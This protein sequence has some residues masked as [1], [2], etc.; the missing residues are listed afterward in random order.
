MADLS[1]RRFLKA[2]GT[3][4]A[5]AGA[6]LL[7]GGLA[8][9]DTE[10]SHPGATTLPYPR[11]GIAKASALK[12]NEPKAFS[13]P[14]E[15]SFC[16]VIKLGR[17]V[18]GGVGPDGDIVA[19]STQC[20]HMGCPLSYDKAA[21]T[22]K[23]GCHFSIFDPEMHGQMV[24]GQATENL[25]RILLEHDEAEDTLYAVAVEGLIYGRQCNVI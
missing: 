17:P 22:F 16:Q 14:D 3:T 20:T 11:S 2:G 18:P 15:D 25:P 6:T 24:D 19:F 12:E 10:Q 13:Y 21:R 8:H 23:C 4:A 9:A 1:R 5:A 7:G